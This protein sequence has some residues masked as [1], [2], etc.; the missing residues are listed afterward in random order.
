MKPVLAFVTAAT[1]LTATSAFAADGNFDKTL[2][3]SGSAILTLSTGSG[4]I[5]VNSGS[6]NQIHIAAHLRANHNVFSNDSNVDQRIQQ[7]A[8]NPPIHQVGNIITV[9][10]HSHDLDELYRNITIDLDVTTP[11]ATTLKAQ[12]GSGD[13]KISNLN[14]D[15][16]AQSGSGDVQAENIAA[17]VRLGTGSGSIRA[18]GVRGEADLQTGSGSIELDQTA[19]GDV[20]AHTGSGFIHLSGVDGGLRADT[21]S[22]S[23]TVDGKLTSEWHV[24]TGSGSLHLNVG[25]SAHFTLNA[26]TG[27]GSLSVEQPI[28]MQGTLNKHHITGTVNGGGPTLRAQTGSGDITIH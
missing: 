16:Y 25:P 24:N 4:Y 5:H 14:S 3:V 19:Q 22:G 21:G 6:D 28:T 15:L 23:I 20:R 13:L 12:T 1:L 8:A 10:E 18:R 27:S 26:E 2:N 9:G 11:K 17:K 7:I